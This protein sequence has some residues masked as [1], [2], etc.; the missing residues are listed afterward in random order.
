MIAS[1]LFRWSM[2]SVLSI[3]IRGCTSFVSNVVSVASIVNFSSLDFR[4]RLLLLVELLHFCL[5]QTSQVSQRCHVLRMPPL[6]VCSLQQITRFKFEL[7]QVLI[8]VSH[9]ILYSLQC[10]KLATTLLSLKNTCLI[11]PISSWGSRVK[12]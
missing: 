7:L 10:T 1:S 2:A 9:T 8:R 12:P 3:A 4:L 5:V 11:P 6:R